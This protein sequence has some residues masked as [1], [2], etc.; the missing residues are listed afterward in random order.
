MDEK[1]DVKYKKNAR[2]L[3]GVL[4]CILFGH[5]NVILIVKYQRSV[6]IRFNVLVDKYYDSARKYIVSSFLLTPPLLFCNRIEKLFNF[7]Q[8]VIYS[9]PR[10][11]NDTVF[12]GYHHL[13]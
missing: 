10:F 9:F 1:T 4:N 13:H 3:T 11:M 7:K 8:A 12:I 5:R 6:K 2:R